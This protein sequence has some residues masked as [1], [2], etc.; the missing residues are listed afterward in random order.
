MTGLFSLNTN[1]TLY[2]TYLQALCELYDRPAEI[3]AFDPTVGARKLRT[4][5]ETLS[6]TTATG[7]STGGCSGG[8]MRTTTTMTSIPSQ[9]QQQERREATV[10]DVRALV[11]QQLQ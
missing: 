5:H 8:S 7:G 10:T 4:F 3:W 6:T 11:Q 1:T 9:L 2:T